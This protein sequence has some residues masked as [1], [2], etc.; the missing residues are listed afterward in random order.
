MKKFKPW[1]V[2]SFLFVLVVIETPFTQKV[3]ADE[4]SDY[5]VMTAKD[6]ELKSLDCGG[7]S[8]TFK[9]NVCE[10]KKDYLQTCR[11]THCYFCNW[12]QNCLNFEIPDE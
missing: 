5:C 12:T 1:L 8:S 4:G 9:V 2:L 7:C 3:I 11:S 10:Y 6:Y